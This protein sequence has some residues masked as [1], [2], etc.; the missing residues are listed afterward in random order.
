MLC[1]GSV[2]MADQEEKLL[3]RGQTKLRVPQIQ[4]TS[5][6]ARRTRVTLPIAGITLGVG[7]RREGSARNEQQER[8][9]NV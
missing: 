7:W 3:N 8:S 9:R 6:S 2:V 4:T 1:L 5:Q